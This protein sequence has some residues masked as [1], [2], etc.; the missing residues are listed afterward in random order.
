MFDKLRAVRRKKL[1]G[2]LVPESDYQLLKAIR[3]D[4][5]NGNPVVI[6]SPHEYDKI[7]LDQW[8]YI[9][10]TYLHE[11]YGLTINEVIETTGVYL[12]ES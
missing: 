12:Q 9:N 3:I 6:P 4:T 8:L 10:A 7:E 5:A 2:R 11:Y 1:P